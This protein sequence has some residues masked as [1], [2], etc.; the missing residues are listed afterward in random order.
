MA[1]TS[2][3]QG[4]WERWEKLAENGYDDEK[5]IMC[6]KWIRQSF[7]GKRKEGKKK[8]NVF[9]TSAFKRQLTKVKFFSEL[10]RSP[11]LNH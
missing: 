2:S 3:E 10:S 11:I 5:I 8:L 1:H 9:F 7:P 6:E 4:S